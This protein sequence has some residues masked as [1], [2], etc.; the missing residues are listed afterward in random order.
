MSSSV[1]ISIL[2][3]AKGPTERL[4]DTALTACCKAIRNA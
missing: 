1:H 2:I 3:V 4:G